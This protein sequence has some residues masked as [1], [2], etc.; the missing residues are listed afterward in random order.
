MRCH[1]VDCSYAYG[2]E[3]QIVDLRRPSHP[4]LVGD[5]AKAAQKQAHIKFL[6]FHDV[7]EVRPG[8]VLTA[9]QPIVLLDA[10]RDPV[11]PKVLAL[12]STPDG[13]FI[14]DVVWPDEM[15][16]P[17]FLVGGETVGN[18]NGTI[19]AR[20]RATL[21][22]TDHIQMTHTPA[23][24]YK[25]KMTSAR[26]LDMASSAATV[27]TSG[28]QNAYQTTKT[29]SAASS[30]PGDAKNSAVSTLDATAPPVP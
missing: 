10:R 30:R 14:H 20:P 12:G 1:S 26:R 27:G 4:K 29:R 19:A 11:H 22:K 5:W 25:T 13:R 2:S 3:G 21:L 8:L 17:F 7:T 6:N 23:K 9:S 18:C 28:Q 16:D 24:T 15:R